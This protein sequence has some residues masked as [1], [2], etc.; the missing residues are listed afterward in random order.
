MR[1]SPHLFVCGGSLTSGQL[2]MGSFQTDRHT[3]I[4]HGPLG[5]GHAGA[6]LANGSQGADWWFPK[7]VRFQFAQMETFDISGG[8]LSLGL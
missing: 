8:A 2:F 7:D 6:H 3:V 5:E 4:S 1:G